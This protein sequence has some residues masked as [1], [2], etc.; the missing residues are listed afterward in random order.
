MLQLGTLL[1]LACALAT[2]RRDALQAQRRGGGAGVRLSQPLRSG[3]A[4]FR[5]RWWTIGFV[6][7][8][9]AWAC[10]SQRSR[11]RPSRSWRPPISGGLVLLAW[12][13]Q[14]W[15]GDPRRAARVARPRSERG[16]PRLLAVTSVDPAP[17]SASYL[18][19]RDDRLRGGR[20]RRIGA[21]LLL[22]GNQGRRQALQRAAARGGRRPAARGRQRRG[23]GAHRGPFRGDLLAIISPWT[24]MAIV[25][26]VGAFFGLARG[27]Q[28]GRRDPGD[29]AH[30]GGRE[31]RLDR[32]A[33][34]SSSATR[35]GT[36]RST[37]WRAASPSPR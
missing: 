35:S 17:A 27:L 33:A 25:A 1:A 20:R 28:I 23:Q 10:T 19:R 32:S 30:L 7:A 34:S 22:S 21:L 31:L 13:A 5:S 4:L 2:Q 24:L 15:F 29:R 11:W 6:I 14:R 18:D 26:G 12:F 9:G 3:A 8:V 36:T 37:S 16:R